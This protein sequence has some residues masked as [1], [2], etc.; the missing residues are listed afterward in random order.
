EPAGSDRAPPARRLYH[1]RAAG[2]WWHVV[3]VSGRPRGQPRAPGR[4]GDAA[5][6]GHG[7]DDRSVLPRDAGPQE[8]PAPAHRP[9]AR[10][11]RGER[12]RVLHDAV[13]PG[14]D[15][16]RAAAGS[17]PA[18]DAGRAA[19]RP[20][21]CRRTRPRA[22]QRGGAPRR[23][24]GEHPARR[25]RRVPHGLRLRTRRRRAGRGR[26]G[27]AVHRRHARLHEP[28][29]GVRPAGERLARRLLLPGLRDVR[30]AHGAVALRGRHRA[31]DDAAA[32][33]RDRARRA[34]PPPGRPGVGRGDRPPQPRSAPH[35]PV[36]RR[37]LAARRARR[38]PRGARRRRL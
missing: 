33:H 20:R 35:R 17:R 14:R 18:R 15:A 8:A 27:A 37:R 34:R 6:Q 30:D 25:R 29:A 28:G 1:R 32:H 38:R 16:A 24:A 10:A 26:E 2:A 5:R 4:E 3:G 23:E 7:G 19:H 21:R 31:C 36:R 13:H 12:G 22:H 9:A 11:R